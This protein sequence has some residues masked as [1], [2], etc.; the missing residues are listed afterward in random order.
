MDETAMTGSMRDIRVSSTSPNAVL[1]RMVDEAIQRHQAGQLAEAEQLYRRVLAADPKNFDALHLLGVIAYSMRQFEPAISLIRQ[2]LAVRQSSADAHYNLANALRGA[3]RLQEAVDSYQR[4]L[5]LRADWA[6]AHNNLAATLQDLGR[7]VE[8]GAAYRRALALKPAWAAA[9]NNLGTLFKETGQ[10][11]EAIQCFQRAI[12][13]QPGW[14]EALNNLGTSYVSQGRRDEARVAYEAA[15]RARPDFAEPEQNL[16]FISQADPAATPEAL[17]AAARRFGNRQ[18][19]GLGPEFADCVADP[20]RRL[21]IGYVSPD[22]RRHS[23]CHFLGPLLAAHDRAEVELFA[24]AEVSQPDDVTERLRGSMDHWRSTVGVDDD[25]VVKMIRQDRIDI[26]VDLAGHTANNRLLVFARRA[27][28]VQVSWLGYAGTTGLSTIDYRLTDDIADPPGQSDF[29]HSERLLRLPNG[30]L[31]YRPPED[32]P[33]AASRNNDSGAITFGSFNALFKLNDRVI[34]IWARILNAL[35]TARLIIKSGGLVDDAVRHRIAD[36]FARGGVSPARLELLGWTEGV[37]EHL[38]LYGRIDIGLDTFPYNGTTTTCEALWMGVPVVTLA[39]DR[40]ASRV[41][42]SLLTRVA[43][44]ELVAT[45]EDDY[46]ARALALARDPGR[47]LALRAG[48]RA[49]MAASPVCDAAGFARSV[50]E[51]YRCIWADWIDDRKPGTGTIQSSTTRA[52]V[53]ARALR[54]HQSGDVAGAQVLY[55]QVLGEAPHHFEAIH[56]LGVCENQLGNSAA[57]VDLIGKAVAIQPDNAEAHS[58]LGTALVA[59]GRFEEAVESYERAVALR[60]NI[61]SLH[62]NL[63]GAQRGARRDKDAIANYRRAIALE[64]NFVQAYNNLGSALIDRFEL[65][66]ALAC[67]RRA[68]ELQPSS[69]SAADCMI[70]ALDLQATTEPAA[71]LAARKSWGKYHAEPYTGSIVGHA[72][73]PDPQRKLR[74]GYVSADFRLHSAADLIATV[75][76]SHGPSVETYCYAN[77]E[78]PDERTALFR[79]AAEAW[80]DVVG[81]SD[82]GVAQ[83]VR[84][85][86]IDILVDLSGFTGGNRLRAFARKPAPIQVQAWG[87]PLG[88]GMDTMDY[89]FADA[90]MIPD[91]ERRHYAEEIVHLPCGY[92]YTPVGGTPGVTPLPA[93]HRGHFTFGS[94]NNILKFGDEM[95]RVWAAILQRVPTARLLVKDRTLDDLAIRRRILDRLAAV[96]VAESRVELRGKTSNHDHMVAMGEVDLVLDSFPRNGGITSIEELMM[97]V[98]MITLP[99]SRPPNRVSASLLTLLGLQE[100]IAASPEDYIAKGVAWA[101]RLDDLAELRAEL[102]KKVEASKLCDRASYVAAVEAAYRMMWRRWCAAASKRPAAPAYVPPVSLRNELMDLALRHHRGGRLDRARDFCAAV[103]D[104]WP[105]HAPAVGLMGGSRSR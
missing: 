32:A 82:D 21:R 15:V 17:F 61:A 45:N 92:A 83:L 68:F 46:V 29:L 24:Y 99:G 5:A 20:A 95:L 102:R 100:F 52:S 85:D 35:P 23:C 88:T 65:D 59:L 7:R 93:R 11:T 101:M 42:A 67:F 55:R 76:M 3:R 71:A 77:V 60:P 38:D 8:A 18:A 70:F 30:F 58:N 75:I 97:G 57:A 36:Q 47:L 28:P 51:V 40:H 41:G 10:L 104:H 74:V 13:L 31:C 73:N 72:N 9:H 44:P 78:L 49:R 22:F 91:A 43:A 86:R 53:L 1:A 25:N 80:R 33:A 103:L 14:A 26:L 4:A 64:P 81:L 39:G 6:E 90:V 63:A 27:A 19:A 50:E 98:P 12:E 105:Q 34:A 66:E 84:A 94:F 79:G 16:L 56:M 87:Y 2:S 54:Q 69:V 96:G 48:L 37:A 89:L 62:Y